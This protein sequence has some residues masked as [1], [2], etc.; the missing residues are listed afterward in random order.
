MDL[1]S[2]SKRDYIKYA[3]YRCDRCLYTWIQEAS[4]VT[5]PKC[6]SIYVTWTNHPNNKET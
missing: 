2:F 6:E 5:C 1:G 4:Q 3:V